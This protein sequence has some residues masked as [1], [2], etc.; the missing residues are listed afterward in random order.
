MALSLEMTVAIVAVGVAVLAIVLY[1]EVRYMKS[2]RKDKVDVA[3]M[4]DDAYNALMTTQAVSR[5]LRDQG[6]NT[7]EADVVLV[8]AEAA[9]ERHDY[10]VSKE[11]AEEARSILKQSRAPEKK[12]SVEEA[13][14]NPVAEIGAEKLPPFQEI[15]KLPQNYLESKFM[16]ETAKMC[17]DE[18]KLQGIDISDA[19]KTLAVASEC[20]ARTEYTE[21]LKNALRAKKAAEGQKV[22]P[23]I[24]A[25]PPEAK[26][27]TEVEPAATLVGTACAGCGQIVDEED[28]FC[29]KCGAAVVRAPKCT[30]CGLEVDEDDA[31]CRRGGA[32]LG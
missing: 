21:A 5:A 2:R 31:F 24:E 15:K 16:I 28:N 13:V 10:L 32:K 25:K 30:A 14:S 18:A 4:R 6:R 12:E 8:K 17:I 23:R 22:A 9:Y 26:E 27:R 20:Y 7:K 3:L 11:L 19:E 29:R 1:L